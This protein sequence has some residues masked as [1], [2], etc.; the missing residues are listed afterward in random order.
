M[1][2]S[3]LRQA[4]FAATSFLVV[5]GFLP[6]SADIQAVNNC[7]FEL[8]VFYRSQ[9]VGNTQLS[10]PQGT[11]LQ[12]N[13][14]SPW[15]GGVMWASQNGNS[16]NAQA[17]QI[18]FNINSAGRDYYDISVVN[19][20]NLP[21]TINPTALAPG[22]MPGGLECGSPTCVIPDPN[23]VCQLNN[24]FTGPDPCCINADGPGVE[25]TPSIDL[26]YN[27]CP[28]AY[29]QS[30]VNSMVVYGCPTG[31]QYDATWCP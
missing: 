20:Y 2:L 25:W 23:A 18:E 5:A 30:N 7:P 12:L 10:V 13:L 15:V 24:F 6:A 22:A 3:Y 19:A 1:A 17:T 21:V 16:N 9:Y 29:V 31:S 8:T 4:A 14:P 27:Q 11:S 26:F 28:S